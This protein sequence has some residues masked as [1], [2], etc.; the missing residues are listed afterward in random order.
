MFQGW[1]RATLSSKNYNE[2]CGF[3]LLHQ[4]F[5]AGAAALLT[6]LYQHHISQHISAAIPSP[7]HW[8]P[9]HTW[10]TLLRHHCS[11]EM[12]VLNTAC[13]CLWSLLLT[14]WHGAV[15]WC[16]IILLISRF[17]K[18]PWGKLS[19]FISERNRLRVRSGWGNE[20]AAHC[21]PPA[22]CPALQQSEKQR[23]VRDSPWAPQHCWG[24]SHLNSQLT[25]WEAHLH[26]HRHKHKF[27]HHLL[28]TVKLEILWRTGN[29]PETHNLPAKG[30]FF[31]AKAI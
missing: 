13:K 12:A 10:F 5:R 15:E 23:D 28:A 26:K 22:L 24:C 29:P 9:V 25:F 16:S 27:W 3:T 19:I 11:T 7:A 6:S 14:G 31:W 4:H 21:L 30:G 20:A 17:G 8:T 18:N 2:A 1:Q